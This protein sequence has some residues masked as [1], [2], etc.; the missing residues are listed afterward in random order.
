MSDPS[1][2]PTADKLFVEA[3]F[4][5]HQPTETAHIREG[6]AVRLG[7]IGN[8]S[9]LPW[10]GIALSGGGIRSACLALGVLQVLADKNLL[11]RFDYISTVSGGG[12]IGGALQWWWAN[13]RRDDG[14]PQTMPTFGLNPDDFPYGPAIKPAKVQK[15]SVMER[16]LLNL[17][18]LR[19]HGSYLTPGDGLTLWSMLVVLLRTVTISILIWLPLLTAVF[20][21]VHLF[22]RLL[23]LSPEIQQLISP[24]GSSP[25][26]CWGENADY[27]HCGTKL[28]VIYA[29][30]IYGFYLSIGSFVVI[31]VLYAFLSRIPQETVSPRRITLSAAFVVLTLICAFYISATSSI[32]AADVS[33]MVIL[34]CAAS[35]GAVLIIRVL[36]EHLP[37][38]SLSASYFLRRGVEKFLGNWFLPTLIIAMIGFIPLVTQIITDKTS[39]SIAGAGAGV[40]SL[41]S[42]VASALYGYFTFIRSIVPSKAGSIGATIGAALYLYG[43]LVLAYWLSIT[44]ADMSHSDDMMQAAAFSIALTAAAMSVFANVNYVGLHRFYRDR[45]METFMP[46]DR[47][48][49]SMH[50]DDSA[51]ADS[52][53]IAAL[54]NS[55]DASGNE[56]KP[57]PLIN[58][59]VVLVKDKF[60]KFAARGGA[61]F[62]ISPL[63]V[64]SSATGWQGSA[65]YIASKGPLTLPTAIAASGAAANASA[66]YVGTGIT[67][68]P[69]VSAVMSLLNIRLGIWVGNPLKRDKTKWAWRRIPSFFNPGLVAGVFGYGHRRTDRYLELTDGGHFENLAIYELV[70]RKLGLI[71]VVDG[72]ADPNINLSSLVFAK[73]RIEQDFGAQLTFFDRQGPELL[74][75]HPQPGYPVG[76]KYAQSPFIVGRLVY[77]DGSVGTL[78]YIKSNITP[79]LDFSTSGYLASN[80]EFPHQTTADQF[81]SPDQ[82]EAYRRLGVES[83]LRTIDTLQLTASISEPEEIVAIYKKCGPRM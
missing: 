59:N 79:K 8:E 61:N 42:G 80:P 60:A 43:T 58:T 52:L 48:V 12:Y 15:A 50:T 51:L 77:V 56:P 66:G 36:I 11:R 28:R 25:P 37:G 73:N 57:Y 46:K 26:A 82:F 4:D 2:V 18:F 10:C 22:D 5:E 17:D 34:F 81:F 32:A 40:F 23:G 44:V 65:E 38:T 9:A 76:A 20:G 67:M 70:R 68:N 41:L 69:L 49:E 13:T 74:V 72:E 30:L 83:A 53:S 47:S 62:L 35:F 54:A 75:M 29:F 39:G 16:A 63:F 19:A 7:P 1:A 24:L 21:I 3:S 6:R 45:L 31:A 55:S 33:L 78:I 64:G 71:L 14:V 27:L